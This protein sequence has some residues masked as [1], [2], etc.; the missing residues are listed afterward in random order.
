MNI[1]D[2]LAGKR[3][4]G[5]P[6]GHF[7]DGQ[8][9]RA[10]NAEMMDSFDAGRGDAFAMF[11]NGTAA[12][13]DEAVASARKAFVNVWRDSAPAERGR[14][15][16]RAASLLREDAERF[17]IVETLDCGKTLSE[18]RG[19]VLG[20]ARAFEYYA[21]ATDK[22]QGASFPLAKGYLG[23]SLNEPMGVSAQII[24]WNYPIST[25]ARGMAPALAAGCCVVAKPA[26]Q[27]PFT[28][29]M[30][31]ELLSRA[32]LPDGVC[33][34][35]TGTGVAVGAP[36]TAHPDINQITFTGLRGHRPTGDAHRR[37][38]CYPAG[39]GAWREITSRRAWRLQS[40]SGHRWC[41]RR[42]LRK[43]RADLLGRLAAGD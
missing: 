22:L 5:L 6:D 36:L 34:V 39:A 17:A 43:C 30:L 4:E 33:N 27:T 10:S 2:I 14:I 38:T 20:A 24:P 28:A 8:F 35:I 19:D 42:D 31:A 41:S 26:E 25:A 21:G 7:I 12:D 37:R 9:R 16:S 3:P 40:R 29:L 13:V 1:E 15:L 18:A 23:F 11:V 32:G